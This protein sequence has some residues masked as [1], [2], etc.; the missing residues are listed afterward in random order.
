MNTEG[1][2][3]KRLCVSS[4]NADLTVRMLSKIVL[5]IGRHAQLAQETQTVQRVSRAL[6]S[7]STAFEAPVSSDHGKVSTPDEGDIGRGSHQAAAVEAGDPSDVVPNLVVPD[8]TSGKV[9]KGLQEA[10]GIKSGSS[11][12]TL[13]T[14]TTAKP[15]G[16][17]HVLFPCQATAT[18]SRRPVPQGQAAA[19]AATAPTPGLAPSNNIPSNKP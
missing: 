17:H 5:S 11:G 3:K 12:A 9:P 7:S 6:Y 16:L 10:K 13:A 18:P 1:R 2:Q 15:V 19:E 8:E 4:T 14:Q